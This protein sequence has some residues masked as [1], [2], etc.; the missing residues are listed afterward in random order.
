MD[1]YINI[2][3]YSSIYKFFFKHESEVQQIKQH[4]FKYFLVLVGFMRRHY[5]TI[6]ANA[7]ADANAPAVVVQFI[8]TPSPA[9]HK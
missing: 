6:I 7:V 2:W 1:V 3:S 4:D 8:K 9:E 5:Q